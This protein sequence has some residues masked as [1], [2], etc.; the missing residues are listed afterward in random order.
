[1]DGRI[2][3]GQ[4]GRQIDGQMYRRTD[5]WGDGW[6]KEPNYVFLT[7]VILQQS[8]AYLRGLALIWPFSALLLLSLALMTYV[9]FLS[10]KNCH[11][12]R[13]TMFESIVQ[14]CI[15]QANLF[16]GQNACKDFQTTSKFHG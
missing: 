9:I 2:D 13:F 10:L 6:V 5:G 11:L 15:I 4:V 7:A 12:L 14:I 16:Q 1:M 8:Q 3:R